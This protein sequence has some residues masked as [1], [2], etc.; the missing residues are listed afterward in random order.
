MGSLKYG[1]LHVTVMTCF[2]FFPGINVDDFKQN[3]PMSPKN[4]TYVYHGQ[5]QVHG[6]KIIV[7]EKE[8]ALFCYRN[9]FYAMDEKCPHLG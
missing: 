3:F 4:G 1:W 9:N 6:K 2:A 8:V 5:S 7:N